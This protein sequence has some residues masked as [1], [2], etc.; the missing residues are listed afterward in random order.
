MTDAR[1]RFLI[2]RR[3]PGKPLAGA[4]E[5][6]G[7][8][9]D[10]GE[11]RPAG[12]ARELR[13]ELGIEI[14]D[15]RPL[16]RVR[17]SYPFGEVLIDMWI[18]N[19]YHGDPRGLDGQTLRWCAIAELGGA[20]LLPADR[21]LV[22]ALRLPERLTE[23]QSPAYQVSGVD[24]SAP[25]A[26]DPLRGAFCAGAAAALR[27]A[28]NVDFIVLTEALPDSQLVALCEAVCVPVFARSVSLE[29]AWRFGA[30]G[31]NAI[32]S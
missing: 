11:A 23:A 21:P 15:P 10:P 9:L 12:L 22:R 5:F 7:G 13:E 8:K 25:R 14:R 18:V 29:A 19:R 6:P 16:M 17:H 31:V 3:P 30:T 27:A 20:D 26:G 32:P 24:V 2:A 1:G 4:W 28:A